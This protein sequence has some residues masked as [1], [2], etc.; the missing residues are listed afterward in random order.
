M[1]LVDPRL[2]LSAQ[3]A[4]RHGL[5]IDLDYARD[6][7]KAAFAHIKDFDETCDKLYGEF[8][9]LEPQGPLDSKAS[10]QSSKEESEKS[11][12][13]SSD[14]DM[15][16]ETEDEKEDSNTDT[17]K[18]SNN[19]GHRTVST[20]SKISIASKIIVFLHRGRAHSSRTRSSRIQK[21]SIVIFT[22]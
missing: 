9:P 12:K 16:L 11:A 10:A 18:K 13:S 21:P 22:T 14:S 15:D 4:L 2:D 19:R 8:F 3:A 1:L 17:A 5:L 20:F 6:I 7:F